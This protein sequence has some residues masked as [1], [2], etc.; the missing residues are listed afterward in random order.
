MSE[1]IYDEMVVSQLI[2]VYDPL[3]VCNEIVKILVYASV[4][5]FEKNTC[6]SLLRPFLEKSKFVI[7]LIA[8][9][10]INISVFLS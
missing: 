4:D 1:S 2:S 9:I 8:K 5:A 7:G 6:P 3:G 10:H